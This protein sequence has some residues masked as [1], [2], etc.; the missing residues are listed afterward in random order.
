MIPAELSSVGDGSLLAYPYAHKNHPEFLIDKE[1]LSV[2]MN[3]LTAAEYR[4]SNGDSVTLKSE[5]GALDGLRVRISS[6]YPPG[7]VAVPAGF[8][9]SGL[10]RYAD[11]RGVNLTRIAS[12]SADAAGFALWS[13]TPVRLA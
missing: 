2:W 3:P 4:V 6:I 9:H 11:G 13:T 8:G 10:T 5:R 7:C 1:E 12:V